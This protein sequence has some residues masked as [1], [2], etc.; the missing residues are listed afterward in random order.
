MGGPDW[1]SLYTWWEGWPEGPGCL[2]PHVWCLVWDG[3]KAGLSG[4]CGQDT[5]YTWSLPVGGPRLSR[6]GKSSVCPVW[7][8]FSSAVLYLR[9]SS[10]AHLDSMERDINPTFPW[11]RCPGI[12]GHLYLITENLNLKMCHNSQKVETTQ[13]LVYE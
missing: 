10:R 7:A 2:S 11:K 1:G 13:M 12:C 6:K 5:P 3:W 9:S 4:C 8:H